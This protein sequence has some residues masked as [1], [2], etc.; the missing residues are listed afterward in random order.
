MKLTIQIHT[1]TRLRTH[2]A[3]SPALI[4]AKS[5]CAHLFTG[6]TSD[7]SISYRLYFTITV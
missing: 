6:T 2:G 4:A 7:S 1:E 3:T 5:G